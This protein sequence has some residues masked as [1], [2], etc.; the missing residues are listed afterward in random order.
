MINEELTYKKYGYKST[1]LKRWSGKLVV[2]RCDNCSKIE[3]TIFQNQAFSLCRSCTHSGDKNSMY[4]KIHSDS[5]LEKMSNSLKGK[6]LGENNPFYG[7]THTDETKKII[8]ESRLGTHLSDETKKK[9]SDSTSGDKN[10]N[11]GKRMPDEV[12]EKLSK[13]VTGFRHTDKSKELMSILQRG[14]NNGFYG[15]KHT[16]ETKEKFRKRIPNEQSL[17]SRIRHSCFL[18][19]IPIEEFGGFINAGYCDKFTQKLRTKI[20]DRYNNCDYISGLPN[21][22][23]NVLNSKVWELDVHHV[24][25]N[26]Q[27][28]CDDYKWALIPLSRS[29]HGKTNSIRS[30]WNRLFV[31]SLEYDKIYYKLEDNDFNIFTI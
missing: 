17:E 22:I 13:S 25:Y 18:R 9:I 11:Y 1:D 20:R 19:G 24:D 26:T 3:D 21:Y 14:E 28:G 4:G 31:Y 15:K 12:R 30:F 6:F 27:Q 29:N 2:R 5:T 8:S 23:C 16:E 10:H 7:K